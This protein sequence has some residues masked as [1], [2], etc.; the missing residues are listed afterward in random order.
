[1]GLT[2]QSTGAH[3]MD[4]KLKIIKESEDDAKTWKLISDKISKIRINSINR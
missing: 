2:K 4:E 1:M 3:A